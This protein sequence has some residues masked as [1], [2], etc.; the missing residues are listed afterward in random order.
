MSVAFSRRP[1]DTSE[2]G[3]KRQT[4]DGLHKRCGC[5]RRVWA[6]CPHPWHFNFSW[7]GTHYRHSLNKL[8]GRKITSKTEAAA[9]ADLLR[10]AIRGG[11]FPSTAAVMPLPSL[12]QLTLA[13]FGDIFMQHCPKRRGKHRGEAR[14]EDDRAKLSRLRQLRG[15]RGPLGVMPIR[16]IT[17]ADL[18]AALHAL[19]AAGASASTFNKY[20][21]LCQ[22]LSKWGQKKGYL[23]SAWLTVDS[24]LRRADER[25][26]QRHRRL[27]PAVIGDDGRVRTLS[28]EQRLLAAASPRLQR[29]IIG[30][31]ETCCREDELMQLQWRHVSVDWIQFPASH[32]KTGELREI[33]IS[34]RLRAVLEMARLDP[35]G[36]EHAPEAFVFGNEV[37][38]HAPFPKKSWETARLRAHGV[39]P[40][41]EP[42]KGRLTA[43]SRAHLAAINLTFHDL[44][45]EGGS[46][47]LEAGWPL[48]HV[49]DMLGHADISTTSRYL[50]AERYGLRESMRRSDEARKVCTTVTHSA[51]E[52]VDG[53]ADEA[54]LDDQKPLIN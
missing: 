30:A 8:L 29:L 37:G 12:E 28:E 49:R 20:L 10:A 7:N 19:T 4:N 17:E 13:E 31:I 2:T 6:K 48:H 33:P 46:R 38:E 52:T 54:E 35:A 42:G 32:T 36:R 23:T 9:E 40:Q 27:A 15:T 24:D 3:K 22:S 43:A 53:A 25:Q 1:H 16:A 50:N 45:H 21:Q 47:L 34:T 41:W 39:T 14:G 18:E 11:T 5:P 44:R 26:G 51:V